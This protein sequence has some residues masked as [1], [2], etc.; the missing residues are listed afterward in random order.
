MLWLL[1]PSGFAAPVWGQLGC[2]PSQLSPDARTEKKTICQA[3]NRRGRR[4]YRKPRSGTQ[5]RAC[6]NSVCG[7]GAA[8]YLHPA[9]PLCRTEGTAKHPRCA[10][11][12]RKGHFSSSHPLPATHTG[13]S[14]RLSLQMGDTLGALEA[15]PELPELRSMPCA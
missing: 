2:P 11:A 13:T 7:G 4:S 5:P 6:T 15:K 12:V 10:T 8:G 1:R 9:L 14:P 3:S